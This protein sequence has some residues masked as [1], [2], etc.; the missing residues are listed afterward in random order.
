MRVRTLDELRGSPD[1]ALLEPVI[2]RTRAMPDV[3]ASGQ[4]VFF[5]RAPGRLDV[6]G[7]IADYSG[8]L[9]LQLPLAEAPTASLLPTD[10]PMIHLLSVR[11]NRRPLRF[12]MSLDALMRGELRDPS[13]LAAWF[14][15]R[16]E[17]RWAS[18]VIGVTHACLVRLGVADVERRG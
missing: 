4:P 13:A 11:P 9:V 14:A 12:S 8:S 10:D 17:E 18:Y 2:A 1:A 6:M 5:A 15:T 7:G 16:D 3:A